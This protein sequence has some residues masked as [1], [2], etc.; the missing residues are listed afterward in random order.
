MSLRRTYALL[1]AIALVLLGAGAGVLGPGS[2]GQASAAGT[3]CRAATKPATAIATGLSINARPNPLTAGAAVRVFGRLTGI[4]R[5]VD[6][7]GISIVLWRRF[8][9]QRGFTAVAR[10]RTLTGGRYSLVFGPGQVTTNRE[11]YATA[12]G[13]VSEVVA[14]Y[15]R[16]AVTLTSSATFA[17]AGDVE[18]LSGQLEPGSVGERVTLQRRVG[19][20]W[21]TEARPRLKR[22]SVYAFVH[23][24]TTGRTEQWRALVPASNRNLG[25]SSSV[26]KI[27]I[28]PATGIHKI[29]HVVIIM[30]EN[31]SFDSYFGTFPGADGIPAGV[32]VPDPGNGGCIAPFHDSSDLNYGGPHSQSNAIADIDDGRMDGFVGQAEQGMGCTSEDPNCSPCT[33]TGQSSSST[34]SCVDVMGY[35]DAR[36]IPNYWTYAEQYVLQDHMF[37]PNESWSLPA[38]LYMVSEWSAYCTNPLLPSSCHSNVQNPNPDSTLNADFSTPNDGELHYAWTDI[39]WLLHQQNVPWDYYVFQGT[40]PD[41]EN[42]ASMTCAPVQQGPQTPGI[43][44]PLPSFT[45][46]TEDGQLGNIQSLS[47]FFTAARDGTLPA[48]SWITPNGT[49]SEHPPALV[50]AGQTY[51]TGLINAIM[52]SPDWNSTAIFLAWDDWGGFYDHVVPPVVDGEGFGLRVP[53]IVISP[54]AKQGYI[55]HQILSFD[56]YTKFIEDDF[57]DS[58]RLNPATDGRP[59]PRPDV[60]E[61]NPILGNLTADFNFN[62]SPRA[63]LILPVHPAPGP[64]STPPGS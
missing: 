23:R 44:N 55:D 35:H 33:E 21:V 29:R 2:S 41:C 1:A 20:R 64:A 22:G 10:T 63:P 59:D 27:K 50:S 57:L 51:V 49:V 17:V 15:V 48:V 40:E 19:P 58:A 7:C 53:G 61:N 25:S 38:H 12:R 36:E 42:D 47:N 28:V 37:E 6:R 45:D 60:R 46:V 31:R 9:G 13:L 34:P 24:F 62:Q 16:P 54:Y 18:T 8:A 43:W 39:T 14:E 26:V 4:R 32:C 56:A 5:G 30:Q 3:P 11:W 52:E